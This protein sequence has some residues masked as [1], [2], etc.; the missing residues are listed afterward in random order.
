MP[1]S[2]S[3]VGGHRGTTACVLYSINE[4]PKRY[5]N[6][7]GNKNP[8]NGNFGSAAKAFSR[9]QSFVYARPAQNRLPHSPD[10]SAQVTESP[11]NRGEVAEIQGG[12]PVRQGFFGM[13]VDF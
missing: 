7:V 9:P 12:W 5:K 1:A 6:L 3:V 10:K 8:R 2:D 13:V 4:L 11:G